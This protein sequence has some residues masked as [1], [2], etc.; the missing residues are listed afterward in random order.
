MLISSKDI[1]EYQEQFGI[2]ELSSMTTSDYCQALE[3]G[4]FIW[5][6]HHDHVRSTF[7]EEVLATNREQVDALIQKLQEYRERMSITPDWMSDQ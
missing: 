3:S 5:I 7:S 2:Q 1:I 4:A 6:D